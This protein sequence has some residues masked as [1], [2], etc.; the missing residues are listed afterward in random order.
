MDLTLI[1]QMCNG[2]ALVSR[3]WGYS[4]YGYVAFPIQFTSFRQIALLHAGQNFMIAKA[5]EENSLDGFTLSVKD[6]TNPNTNNVDAD[7]FY[8]AHY[9]AIGK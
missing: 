8:D 2:L 1:M 5:V 9:I 6:L 3:Q 4:L 7:S